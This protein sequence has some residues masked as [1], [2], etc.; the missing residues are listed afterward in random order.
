MKAKKIE[1]P[2]WTAQD[3]KADINELGLKGSPTQVVKIFTP[4]KRGKG[5]MLE[6]EP[7][8][9]A[10]ELFIRLRKDSIL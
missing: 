9:V 2:V 5:E 1:I 7:D 8:K 3:I 10:D 6:G 4:P